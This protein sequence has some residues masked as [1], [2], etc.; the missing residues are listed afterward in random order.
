M[1]EELLIQEMLIQ[2]GNRRNSNI[3]SQLEL[4]RDL[5]LS[6]SFGLVGVSLFGSLLLN[7]SSLKI[8]SML[9]TIFGSISCL[10]ITFCG[11][12]YITL[13]NKLKE[14]EKYDIYLSMYQD[15]ERN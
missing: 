2:A 11:I 3:K 4:Q 6:F 15:L 13:N 5:A 10:G 9:D 7:N 14:L 8:S 12:K 1:D